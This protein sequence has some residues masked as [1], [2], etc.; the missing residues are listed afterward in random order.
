MHG[1][2]HIAVQNGIVT[3]TTVNSPCF[4]IPRGILLCILHLYAIFT[5]NRETIA[6]K[7]ATV[8][9]KKPDHIVNVRIP[10]TV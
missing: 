3:I 8:Y 7:V 10:Y 1:L 9:R 4:G 2:G 5:C 6:C